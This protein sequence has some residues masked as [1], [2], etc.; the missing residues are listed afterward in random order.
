[1]TDNAIAD[2]RPSALKDRIFSRIF[3][4]ASQQPGE[5][6]HDLGEI[7]AALLLNGYGSRKERQVWLPNPTAE[8]VDRCGLLKAKCHL[9]RDNSEFGSDRIGHLACDQRPAKPGT[10]DLRGALGQ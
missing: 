4:P 9:V 5:T 7:A 10:D 8:I 6:R 1:M 2:S 3:D